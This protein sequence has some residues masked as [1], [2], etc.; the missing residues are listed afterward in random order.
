MYYVN[1]KKLTYGNIPYNFKIRLVRLASLKDL[2]NL[3]KACP[4][5]ESH[6]NIRHELHDQVKI[7]DS[8]SVYRSAVRMVFWLGI[9]RYFKFLQYLYDGPWSTIPIWGSV[10]SVN[11]IV[12]RN[13][14]IY[15]QDTLVLHC[16]SS[17][18]YKKV[19]P[20]ITGPY[21]RLIIDG[22]ITWKQAKQLITAN[23]KQV[24]I[25]AKIHFWS[26]ERKEFVKFIEQFCRGTAY[27]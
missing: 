7:A 27:K 8:P 26:K 23:V 2:Y 11:E 22:H 1:F 17:Q 10:L 13:K 24:R 19:I 18:G 14:L 9:F 5:V 20:F 15:V 3:G 4:D 16:K 21:S 6:C 12:D 25:D